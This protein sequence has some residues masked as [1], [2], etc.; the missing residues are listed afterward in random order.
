MREVLH[1]DEGLT[2]AV[3][4]EEDRAVVE[5][6]SDDDGPDLSVDHE[7]V[8]VVDGRGREVAVE[9]PK[10]ARATIIEELPDAPEPLMLMVR[11]HEFFEGWELFAEPE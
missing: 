7:V 1:D 5:L 4:L 2:V 6:E 8:V 11:V 9:G 3:V 10:R